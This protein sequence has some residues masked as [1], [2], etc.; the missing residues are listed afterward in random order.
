MQHFGEGLRRGV[1][2]EVTHSWWLQ[3]WER[4]KESKR[5]EG[6][7]EAAGIVEELVAV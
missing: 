3:E 4:W 1:E 7:G 5:D 2:D 6:R